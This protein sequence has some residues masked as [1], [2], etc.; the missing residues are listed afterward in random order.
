VSEGKVT[1]MKVVYGEDDANELLKAEWDLFS[2]VYRGTGASLGITLVKRAQPA[3][4]ARST[5][6]AQPR[7]AA[8]PPAA[9]QPKPD[10]PQ[11]PVVPR[12]AAQPQPSRPAPAPSRRA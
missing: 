7:K 3:A 11:K 6:A 4:A 1:E 2:V 5:A 9:S 12:T 8:A 10:A